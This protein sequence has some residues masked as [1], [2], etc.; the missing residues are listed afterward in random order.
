MG[1][2]LQHHPPIQ[3]NEIQRKQ[4]QQ[5]KTIVNGVSKRTPW[6]SK[7]MVQALSSKWLLKHYAIPSTIYYGVIKDSSQ[8]GK[9]K[10]HA[11]LKIGEEFVSGKAGHQQFKVVNFY[12]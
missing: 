9:L 10:A 5:I 7:C 2:R 8:P 4:V 11:W 12:S 1:A 3:L 6:E